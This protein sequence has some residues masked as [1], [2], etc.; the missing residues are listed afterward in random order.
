[1][2][3][4]H[5][6]WIMAQEISFWGGASLLFEAV[7]ELDAAPEVESVGGQSVLQADGR[8]GQ[9]TLKED[10]IPIERNHE[11]NDDDDDDVPG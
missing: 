3:I 6:N 8:Q 11:N 10:I 1:M 2:Y 7:Y 4:A 5:D 9:R